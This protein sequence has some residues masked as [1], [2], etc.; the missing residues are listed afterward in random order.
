[1]NSDRSPGKLGRLAPHARETHPRLSFED[2]LD[3]T[4]LPSAPHVVDFASKV[5]DW[6][7]YMN[8]QIGDCTC[9]AVG[10]TIQAWTAYASSQV[11]IPD[12]A[13]LNLYE[14]VTGYVPGDP[15]TD[16]GANM[17]DILSYWQKNSVAGHKISAFAEIRSVNNPWLMKQALDIFGTVYIGFN[18]PQSALDQFNA[19]E[20]WSYDASSPIVGGHC[21]A[22]QQMEPVGTRP[23]IMGVITWGALQ[24]MTLKFAENYIEEAWVMLTPD[25][26][27]ANGNSVS[28]F[29]AAQLQA[30]FQAI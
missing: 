13:V 27:E 22:L 26:I 19:G 28:G 24:P 5:T 3:S 16:N 11:T 29:N 18:C 17:Q 15:S 30:D 8:D 1:M 9:A 14:K 20:P 25:W 21:V 2:Y 23:G 7:M 10:H 4:V 6:P 12:S